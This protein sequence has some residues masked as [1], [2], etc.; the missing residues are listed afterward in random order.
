MIRKYLAAA[1]ILAVMSG[2]VSMNASAAPIYSKVF[3]DPVFREYIAA[4]IDTDRDGMLSERET[5]A[6]ERIII[7]DKRL[8]SIQGIE[9]FTNLKTLD[10]S[11]SRLSSINLGSNRA[12][13]EL[14]CSGAGHEFTF[15][16]L[17]SNRHLRKL[18]C[19]GIGVLTSINL[20]NCTL[21]EE[22]DIGNTGL[23][24]LNL[25]GNQV[26]EDLDLTHAG[27]LTHVNLSR[28]KLKR[29]DFSRN[30]QLAILDL[31]YSALEE[32]SLISNT[33]L[34]SLNLQ[35]NRSLKTLDLH[36]H[37][38]LSEIN[39]ADTEL[40]VLILCN[41]ALTDLDLS[42]IATLQ[43]ANLDYNSRLVSV[44]LSTESRLVH[45]NLPSGI[46]D[47]GAYT[48]SVSL[49]GHSMD[50][51]G[52][53]HFHKDRVTDLQNVRFADGVFTVTD[54]RKE[55]SYTYQCRESGT[56]P[57]LKV[58]LTAAGAEGSD[59]Q[60][61]GGAEQEVS[62]DTGKTDPGAED[63]DMQDQNA[64]KDTEKPDAES[65]EKTELPWIFT[66]VPVIPGG[67]KYENIRF[68]YN[69][70]IMGA[71]GAGREFQ[72]DN[73]LTRAMFTT[74]LYR[75]AGEPE[76]V[77]SLK[78]L[79]VAAGRWYSDAVIWANEAGIAEGYSDGRYGISDPITREQLAKMLYL[80]GRKAG[81]DVS[82]RALPGDF[83][84]AHK[85]S[86]WAEAPVQ[87]AAAAGMISGKPNGDGSFRL[88]PR[89]KATRA[90]C[91]KMTTMFLRNAVK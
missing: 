22:L 20:S 83:T 12:L 91:A 48:S 10:V 25:S 16:D 46:T 63:P 72:P 55:A 13:E 29:A 85:V 23:A 14:D 68:V 77:Y 9:L 66:D 36:Y 76:T 24:N 40:E 84:D 64:P 61:S 26:M 39:L 73:L 75:M 80:Y 71:V 44:S 34:I 78:F 69:H 6:V 41:T 38:E 65:A 1:G 82:G 45:L 21:L 43:S 3:P 32:L 59:V 4:E 74:I 50:I 2:A 51:T 81:Y 79:D 62:G 70:H 11:D 54:P 52:F 49:S 35:G 53:A 7:H 42:T 15:L 47:M 60:G 27:S 37:T 28:T 57:I 89:G 31:S 8:S 90:E 58:R 30:L 67:W 17:G 33:N 86:S 5:A 87:W 18:N 19:N 88:D 56:A